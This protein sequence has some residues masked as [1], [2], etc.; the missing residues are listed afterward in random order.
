MTWNSTN[1][2]IRHT[3]CWKIGPPLFTINKHDLRIMSRLYTLTFFTVIERLLAERA[4]DTRKI[5]IWAMST[6]GKRIIAWCG[7]ITR[8]TFDKVLFAEKG[9]FAHSKLHSIW[10]RSTSLDSWWIMSLRVRFL[11][12]I[13]VNRKSFEDD[14]TNYQ[15][16][17]TNNRNFSL[18]SSS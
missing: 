4:A 13:P 5:N 6:R 17:S 3:S 9:R 2:E 18:T 10:L 16:F 11:H 15:T 14:F 1:K 8:L 12:H 7:R